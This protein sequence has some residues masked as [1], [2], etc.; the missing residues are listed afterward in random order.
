[1]TEKTELYNVPRNTK[2]DVSDLGLTHRVSGEPVTELMFGHLDGMY[3]YCT[4]M[5]G[6]LVHLRGDTL[7]KIME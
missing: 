3:S 5:N 7:V 4:D 1:M 6:N 2:I